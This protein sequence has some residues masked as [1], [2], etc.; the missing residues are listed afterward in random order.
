MSDDGL[1][2]HLEQWEALGRLA[3]ARR[4]ALA[5]EVA[6]RSR[7][8][9]GDASLARR[10]GDRDATDLLARELRIS[11]QEAR[12][13]T[14]LGIRV[15]A[16]LS[17]TGE[18]LPSR[19]PHVVA[20]LDAG[21]IGAD[22]ARVIV[23]VLGAVVRRADRAALDVA[24]A[25]LADSATTMS[26]DLLRVQA[27]VWRAALDPDG[28]KPAEDAAHRNRSLRI[29]RDGEDGITTTVLKTEPEIT[30]LLRAAIASH[31][32]GVQWVREAAA[33]CEDDSEWHE[34]AADERSKA[35]F[36]H[37]TIIDLLKAGLRADAD[38]ASSTTAEP[39]V[40]V[41]VNAADLESRRGCG[42]ADGASGR[43]S[44]PTV[45][46]LQCSGSTRLVVTG[47][48]GEPLY[49]GRKRRLFSRAQRRALA[50]R[51]GGCAWPG[52]TAATQWTEGHHIKWVTRDRGGTD[53]DNGVLLCSFH[54][55]LIHSSDEWE[56]RVHRNAPHLVPKR[57]RGDPLPR[58]RMQRHRIHLAGN[59][60]GRAA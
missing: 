28:A 50:A 37:D 59:P 20:A 31:R 51:D 32:I 38:S 7:E 6:W 9:I 18:E 49:L 44:V 25:A 42:W 13:R 58:H 36:D 26:P 53:I 3:D 54:H 60:P 12:R 8:Q 46:R 45:Q 56:I 15:R 22:A 16:G 5:G 57:W 19:W 43:I 33:D 1:L 35:Q 29:G 11:L 55:H 24:E 14:A 30:A 47:V 4:A 23:D 34:A 2:A 48:D 39:E 27:E 52:C 10:R 21:A 40:V 17:I 41:H